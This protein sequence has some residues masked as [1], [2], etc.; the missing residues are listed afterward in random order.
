[1]KFQLMVDG[2]VLPAVDIHQLEQ[3]VVNLSDDV[4][5]FIVLAPESPIEDSIYL[6]AALTDQQYMLET[7]LVNG[8]DFTHY[9]YTTLEMDK[10][11]QMFTA[12]FRDQQRP[13]LSQWQNVT[14]EF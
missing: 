3:A 5:S 9:R 11:V 7:R 6:Q 8:E 10:A 1:M 4:S 14:D 2:H 13:D 12:Y